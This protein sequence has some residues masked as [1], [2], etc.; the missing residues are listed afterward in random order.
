[1]QDSEGRASAHPDHGVAA[2]HRGGHP[3]F[4][5]IINNRQLRIPDFTGNSMFNT[6][7]NF[8]CN[9]YAGLIFIDFEQGRLLQL[10]GKAEILWDVDDPQEEP[11]GPAE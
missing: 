7:G 4:V 8:V 9:P 1:M 5:H 6:L 10:T 11:G 2:S 3:G